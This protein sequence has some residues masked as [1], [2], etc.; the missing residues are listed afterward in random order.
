M[1]LMSAGSLFSTVL[2]LNLRYHAGGIRKVPWII[3]VLVNQFLAKKLGMRQ[4]VFRGI[5]KAV[6]TKKPK[7]SPEEEEEFRPRM[8]T[9]FN[10]SDSDFS[11]LISETKPVRVE[12]TAANKSVLKRNPSFHAIVSKGGDQP[13]LDINR[14]L[15]FSKRPTCYQCSTKGG[16]KEIEHIQEQLRKINR[17]LYFLQQHDHCFQA[18]K[19]ANCVLDRFFMIIFLLVIIL[20]SIDENKTLLQKIDELKLDNISVENE[21]YTLKKQL[22]SLEHDLSLSDQR[23]KILSAKL[24]HYGHCEE[25]LDKLTPEYISDL[26][27]ENE[28]LRKQANLLKMEF[29]KKDGEQSK[30]LQDLT[31]EN[32]RM[33][34]KNRNLE[35]FQSILTVERDEL[36]RKSC[37]LEEKLEQLSTKYEDQS[38]KLEQTER[39]LQSMRDFWLDTFQGKMCHQLWTGILKQT[40]LLS[41]LCEVFSATAKGEVVSFDFLL[42]FDPD[43]LSGPGM[44]SFDLDVLLGLKSDKDNLATVEAYLQ[45]LLDQMYSHKSILV[46][47]NSSILDAFAKKG[48]ISKVVIS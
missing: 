27:H 39:S 48:K 34:T 16:L 25:E 37:T 19:H 40:N 22:S 21:K 23:V 18:W 1:M 9:G 43:K 7:I 24:S 30:V 47:L 31:Q 5:N 20:S 29:L 38:G 3:D 26:E 6:S 41:H 4:H 15:Y 28:S 13:N 33:K 11:S 36:A 45:S 14:E 35:R 17:K 46:D 42:D 2:L 32:E 44:P 12:Q 8:A 10:H